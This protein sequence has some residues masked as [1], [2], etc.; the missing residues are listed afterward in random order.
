MYALKQWPNQTYMSLKAKLQIMSS[1]T[2][3]RNFGNPSDDR[4]TLL[5]FCDRTSSALTSGPSSSRSSQ[6]GGPPYV[7]LVLLKEKE[8][9]ESIISSCWDTKAGKNWQTLIFS[10]CTRI[11]D[12][13]CSLEF[14]VGILIL[15][16]F[17]VSNNVT[18]GDESVSLNSWIHQVM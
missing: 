12:F 11:W 17:L 13:R 7:E 18:S 14:N 16:A 10:R 5:N 4:Q 8:S 15:N 9:L 3:V 1:A 2:L 6:D